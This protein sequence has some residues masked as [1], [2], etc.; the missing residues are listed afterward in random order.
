MIGYGI[1]DRQDRVVTLRPVDRDNWRAIADVAPRDDQRGF[2]PP[3]AARYLLLSEYGDDWTSL[4][5]Y[6]GD[7]VTGHAMWG[8]DE[9]AFW[10]GGVVVDASQQGTG[11][12]RAAMET[13]IRWFA[14]RPESDLVRLTYQPDNPAKLLYDDLGF[15]PTG[16]VDG[17]ELVA[18]LRLSRSAVD[19]Q[20]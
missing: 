9:G 7:E 8:L 4:G 10:I 5:V 12:G 19:D 3:M 15:V 11:I 18:E 17:D 16:E 6:A 2:V 14:E 1:T 13:L 20:G